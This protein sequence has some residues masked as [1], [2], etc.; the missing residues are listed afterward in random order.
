[1]Y[2]P[3]RSTKIL[4]ALWRPLILLRR[5]PSSSLSEVIFSNFFI[6]VDFFPFILSP[7]SFRF[8]GDFPFLPVHLSAFALGPPFSDIVLAAKSTPCHNGFDGRRPLRSLPL[9]EG[10]PICLSFSLMKARAV[11]QQPFFPCDW[12]SPMGDDTVFPPP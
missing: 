10:G 3:P 1:L 9:V 12:L 7:W 6:G 2:I 5:F 11:T 4:P 8:W